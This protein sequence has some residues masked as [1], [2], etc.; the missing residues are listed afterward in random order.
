M[1]KKQSPTAVQQFDV[2]GYHDDNYRDN[3]DVVD[4]L[5]KHYGDETVGWES[6]SIA[7]TDD[8]VSDVS[9]S[10]CTGYTG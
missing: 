1:Q 6:D 5:T 9:S 10:T 8:T 2:I 4:E 3:S 7:G